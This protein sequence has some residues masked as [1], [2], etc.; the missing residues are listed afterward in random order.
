VTRN[1]IQGW[2]FLAIQVL[3][4][5]GLAYGVLVDRFRNPAIIPTATGLVMFPKVYGDGSRE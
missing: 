4:V 5:L 2:L 3:G 1:S